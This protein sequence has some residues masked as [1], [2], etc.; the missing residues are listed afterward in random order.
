MEEPSAAK[1][2][3]WIWK[4]K[5]TRGIPPHP[6]TRKKQSKLGVTKS[7]RGIAPPP[8]TRKKKIKMKSNKEKQS[9]HGPKE[10]ARLWGTPGKD[11]SGWRGLI[12]RHKVHWKCKFISTDASWSFLPS[13]FFW[14]C[15]WGSH[16]EGISVFFVF[17]FGSSYFILWPYKSVAVLP[18]QFQQICRSGVPGQPLEH[19]ESPMCCDGTI[20]W[21]LLVAVTHITYPGGGSELFEMQS[22]MSGR[23]TFCFSCFHTP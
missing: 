11:T 13:Q 14:Y 9:Q 22:S 4:K 21:L 7:T 1:H 20:Y 19:L 18:S 5:S 3:G 6:H 15:T 23:T 10:L 16:L 8:T 2:G 12:G 17:F